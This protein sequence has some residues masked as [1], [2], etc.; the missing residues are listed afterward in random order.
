MTW[1]QIIPGVY[2]GKPITIDTGLLRISNIPKGTMVT[3]RLLTWEHKD[4]EW[5]H[6]I[7]DYASG[8]LNHP[9]LTL[10]GQ[11]GVGKTH[12]ALAIGFE[13]L[14]RGKTVLYYQ[15]ESLLDA[16]RDGYRLWEKH[17]H[18]G[19][20]S[21]LAFTQNASLLILDD[22]GA[23]KETEW[24]VAKLDQIVDY[25]YINKRPLIVTSNLALNRL[26]PRIADRLIE[27]VVIH[28]KGM[29]YRRKKGDVSE[30]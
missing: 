30:I 21:L 9:F 11:P 29:S 2:E 22:F 20:H 4:N 25:R 16:L 28:L 12:L 3:H 1:S 7:E 15:V 17:D 27:G 23:Q 24:T 13:W 14:E 6:V 26:L 10:I 18:N 8:R 19:Y 5:W